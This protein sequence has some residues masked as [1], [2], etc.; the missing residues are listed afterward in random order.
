MTDVKEFYI[1]KYDAVIVILYMVRKRFPKI[2][3]FSQ[4][5][6]KQ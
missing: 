1:R 2:K 3:K 4:F 6:I 5:K